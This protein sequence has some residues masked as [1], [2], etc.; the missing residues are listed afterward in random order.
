MAFLISHHWG[1]ILDDGNSHVVSHPEVFDWSFRRQYYKSFVSIFN[2]SKR[3]GGSLLRLRHHTFKMFT[4]LKIVTAFSRDW[5]SMLGKEKSPRCIWNW[6]CKTLLY[7]GTV[8]IEFGDCVSSFDQAT[9]I[10]KRGPCTSWKCLK[11][12]TEKHPLKVPTRGQ[13]DGARFGKSWHIQTP[14]ETLRHSLS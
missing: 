4:P 6:I 14:R 8:K 3:H 11:I 7:L 9:F 13:E 2:H 12:I 1:L 5:I 10:M